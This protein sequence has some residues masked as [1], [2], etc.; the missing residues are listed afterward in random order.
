MDLNNHVIDNKQDEH[1]H[2]SGV[3]LISRSNK[4]GSISRE[5]FSQRQDV[6]RN[7]QKINAYH[8]SHIGSSYSI[9]GARSAESN[10]NLHVVDKPTLKTVARDPVVR[11]FVEPSNSKYNP[12]A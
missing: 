7:R 3:A 12:F 8:H 10:N 1:F 4:V 5:T 9:S 6:E 11:H 2:T